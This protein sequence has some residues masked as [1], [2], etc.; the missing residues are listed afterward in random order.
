MRKR[1]IFLL[2]AVTATGAIYLN[3]TS[4]LSGRAAGKPVVLPHR[5]LSQEFDSAGLEHG[6]CTAERIRPASRK[7]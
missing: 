2:L 3:N 4:L 1:N 7:A 6:T 5:G